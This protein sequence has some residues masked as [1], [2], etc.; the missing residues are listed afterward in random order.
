M[1]YVTAD[2]HGKFDQ[3][4]KLLKAACFSDEDW[5]FIIGDVID[6][7]FDGGVAIL[8]WLLL[9]P[10]VQLILGNHEKFLLLNRWLFQ[11]I[12]DESVEDLDA[13]NLAL[14]S[15]WRMNGG[16]VTIEALSLQDEETR[17]SILAYLDD[18]PLYETVEVRE[19]TFLLVH[20]GLGGFRKDRSLEDYTPQELLWERPSFDVV[21]APENYTVI[22]GHT[23]TAF[24]GEQYKN[25]ILKA[26]SFW[27]I[28]TG[29]SAAD[30][31]PMLLCL[32]TLKEYYIEADGSVIER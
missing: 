12:N 30:G 2:I 27:D 22:V 29:A 4:Q 18:C 14:L 32:D 16:G 10:N 20:G 24:Y 19:R 28:D 5:L 31:S 25:R 17:Q 8:K 6:R 13:D 21:Y 26:K 11:E 3:L 15:A 1:I 23:P 9:Q 7:N